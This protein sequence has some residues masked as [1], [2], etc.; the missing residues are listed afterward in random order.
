MMVWWLKF[1]VLWLCLD[2][3]ILSTVW[4]AINEIRPRYPNWWKRVIV[5]DDPNRY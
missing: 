1:V 2:V 4:Y 3:V 5:D